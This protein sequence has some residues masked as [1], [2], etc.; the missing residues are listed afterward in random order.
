M[1][2]KMINI[3]REKNRMKDLTESQKKEIENISKKYKYLKVRIGKKA[4]CDDVLLCVPINNSTQLA[5]LL[6]LI[7]RITSL[8]IYGIDLIAKEEIE[9]T[10]YLIIEGLNELK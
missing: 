2:H 5:D 7:E 8:N 4:I 6:F 3:N 1:R 9:T 10:K